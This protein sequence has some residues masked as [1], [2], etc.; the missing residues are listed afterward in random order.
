MTPRDLRNIHATRNS[1]RDALPCANMAL[2]LP[3]YF[4]LLMEKPLGCYFQGG[5]Y[6]PYAQGDGSG[7]GMP[8]NDKHHT[9]HIYQQRSSP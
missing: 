8:K 9:N 4:Y 3:L 5:R 2:K 7:L 6:F 1:C